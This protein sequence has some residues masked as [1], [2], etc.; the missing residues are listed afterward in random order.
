MENLG[1]DV[2]E[3]DVVVD[4]DDDALACQKFEGLSVTPGIVGWSRCRLMCVDQ[5]LGLAGVE[6][7]VFRPL[8]L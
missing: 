8:L 7:C 1:I 2:A 5:R 6:N 4:D 3:L